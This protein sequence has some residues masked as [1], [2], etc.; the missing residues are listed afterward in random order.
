MSRLQLSITYGVFPLVY[1]SEWDHESEWV[2]DVNT[3]FGRRHFASC[4]AINPG[5]KY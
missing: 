5:R 2:R 1:N 3:R 4:V